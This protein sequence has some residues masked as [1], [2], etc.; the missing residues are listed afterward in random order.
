MS[1]IKIFGVDYGLE[2]SN[3]TGMRMCPAEVTDEYNFDGVK[4][5]TLH[6]H[7]SDWKISAIPNTDGLNSW[8]GEFVAIHN[9][10]GYVYGDFDKSVTASSDTAFNHFYEHHTPYY[11]ND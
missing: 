7:Y 11:Y 4:C 8:I 1:I 6:H 5:Y 3:C 9:K 2:Y 10:H